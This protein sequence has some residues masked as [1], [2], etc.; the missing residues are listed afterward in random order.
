MSQDLERRDRRHATA[1]AGSGSA[2]GPAG[3]AAIASAAGSGRGVL[4]LG[5]RGSV[6]SVRRHPV[7]PVI[8]VRLVPSL[9]GG[10]IVAR[11]RSACAPTTL[12]RHREDDEY[13]VLH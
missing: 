1:A 4:E 2:G 5:N 11:L 12:V 7:D 13:T 9:A 6:R 10:D 8:P 3:A